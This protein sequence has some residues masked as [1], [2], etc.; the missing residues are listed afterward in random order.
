MIMRNN[1]IILLYLVLL[2]ASVSFLSC[3]NA[4]S[5]IDIT[6]QSNY[7]DIVAAIDNVDNSLSEKMTLIESAV[8]GGFADN[9]EAQALLQQAVASLSGSLADKLEALE[10]AVESGTSSLEIKLG[11]IEAAVTQGFADGAAQQA[12]IQKAVESLSGKDSEKLA[13]IESAIKNQT[14]TLETKLALIETS[15]KNGL[16]D[17][18]SAQVLIES[19]I[20]SLTGT[21]ADKLQAI[22]T[23]VGKQTTSFST[24]INLI[25]TTLTSG[26]TDYAGAISLIQKAVATL[27]G[28]A[29][30]KLVAVETAV[31]SQT[32]ALE[33]KLGLI[34]TATAEGF[35]GTLAQQKLLKDA[36]GALNGTADTRLAEIQGAIASQGTS[37]SY[38]LGLI[39]AAISEGLATSRQKQGLISD[40]LASLDETLDKKLADIDTALKNQTDSLSTKLGLI[41]AELKSGLASEATALG[42]IKE[43]ITALAGILDDPEAAYSVVSA[44]DSIDTQLCAEGA[45]GK[46]L[47]DILEAVQGLN[48]TQTLTRILQAINDFAFLLRY[49]GHEFVD[50]GLP[51]GLK[52][53]TC[54]VGATTPEEPGDHFAWGETEP[55]KK[56]SW[57]TYFDT[58][59]Y[60]STFNKYTRG[61]KTVLEAVD[62]AA[63]A[64]W[65]GLWRMPTD[66]DWL[67][68]L[69]NCGSEWTTQNEVK[70]RL[71][72]SENGA[73]L[74]LPAAG[75]RN[76]TM[77][78]YANDYGFF[79]S[80]SLN[81][82]SPDNAYS[83]LIFLSG[84]NARGYHFRFLG[85]S[86][87][88]V[89]E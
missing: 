5:D 76:G 4:H 18:V 1:K 73:T 51:S 46:T 30:E 44:I 61:K 19:A 15:I 55:K 52:W 47:S 54:N 82:D 28:T 89:I 7:S 16:A 45:I 50:L 77:L 13:Q 53:A 8:T 41:A 59:D 17:V 67:E 70:G 39:E 34:A 42:Q 21:F 75:D 71:F 33:T 25:N 12:L 74:F 64:N 22:E 84:A 87:R 23:A 14:V 65:G 24:K 37:L 2:M 35:A 66:A 3:E 32:T 81:T 26:L 69:D 20:N 29:E 88:P 72:T 78:N 38:K 80:S 10:T 56:Y 58:S 68:L 60:G 86:V 57:D 83:L 49:N 27:E 9:V 6:L 43:V 31:K 40:A 11:L 62:D 79:W 63:T 85:L 48:Y 36:V